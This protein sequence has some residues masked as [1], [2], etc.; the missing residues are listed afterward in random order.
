MPTKLP[1][2]TVTET[3]PLARRLELAATR[4]PHRASS[5]ADL[6]VALT[7]LAEDVLEDPDRSTD[8]ATAKLRLLERTR[9]LTADDAA[10]ILEAREASWQP[11]APT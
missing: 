2:I 3:A 4:F 7:E 6:L 1:R 11:N 5:R 8:R 10:A 9:Q